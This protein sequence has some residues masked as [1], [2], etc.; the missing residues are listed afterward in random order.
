MSGN[1]ILI[2][3]CKL[4]YSDINVSEELNPLVTWNHLSGEEEV[5]KVLLLSEKLPEDAP[6]RLVFARVVL[7]YLGGHSGGVPG[8]GGWKRRH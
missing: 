5:N 6:P 8:V 2:L 4:Y 1:D 3:S 7:C